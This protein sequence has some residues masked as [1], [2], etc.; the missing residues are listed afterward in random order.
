METTQH[1]IFTWTHVNINMK[2]A[3]EQRGIGKDPGQ[4]LVVTE[5]Y[6]SVPQLSKKNEAAATFGPVAFAFVRE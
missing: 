1:H 5:Y 2:G 4:Y 3:S 6:V